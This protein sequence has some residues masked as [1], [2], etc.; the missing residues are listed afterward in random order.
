MPCL[1]RRRRAFPLACVVMVVVAMARSATA[2][3]ATPPETR[4]LHDV[5]H[6]YRNFFSWDSLRWLAVGGVISIAVAEADDAV[7]QGTEDPNAPVTRA[8][9]GGGTG[10]TYG[11]LTLQ[12]PL[13][14]GWWAVSRLNDSARGAAAGR[15]LLRAQISAVSWTYAIKYAV[16][17]ERPNGDPRSFPSGHASATFATAMVLQEH[18]GWKVGVPVFAAAAYTA[19]SRVTVNKHWASDVAFGAVVG[20]VSGR[21]AT[22]H[23]PN[24]RV[25]VSPVVLNGGA[26]ILVTARP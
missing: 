3:T 2:Q 18:Y 14:L 19:A 25:S 13:A 21:I 17:R 24:S 7:R 10:A 11:N 12:V 23:L 5:A 26:A 22:R 15:D 4:F 8:L 20:M 16:N 1:W 9:E 6:D